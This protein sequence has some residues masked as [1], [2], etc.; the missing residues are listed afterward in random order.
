M[1]MS[2]FA[3]LRS[4]HLIVMHQLPGADGI[5]VMVCGTDASLMVLLRCVT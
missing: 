4:T 5:A 2:A 1:A 3:V